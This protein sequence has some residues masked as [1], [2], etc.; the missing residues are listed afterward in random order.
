MKYKKYIFILCLAH[1]FG[2]CGESALE[3]ASEC[4]GSTPRCDGDQLITCEFV[5][6]A[7]QEQIQPE[8]CKSATLSVAVLQFQ[9]DPTLTTY[10]FDSFETLLTEALPNAT[11]GLVDISIDARYVLPF[12]VEDS[13]HDFANLPRQEDDP[14]NFPDYIHPDD[15]PRLWY[16]YKGVDQVLTDVEHA[17]ADIDLTAF[18]LIVVITDVS[19]GAIAWFL[20]GETL[21]FV[22]LN[23]FT[24]G[25]WGLGPDYT[26]RAAH[27]YS[28]VDEAIH[29][30]G[31]Y[32]GLGHSC[33]DA[34]PA[35]QFDDSCCDTCSSR[36]D[37][38]SSICR[39]RPSELEDEFY[40]SF[41]ACSLEHIQ[42]SFVPAFVTGA[43]VPVQ[44]V[45]C[46]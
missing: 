16:W 19:L 36:G 26:R 28:L 35:P 40:N 34:C 6:G 22:V 5:D 45:S 4:N 12:P 14:D 21:S 10:N 27:E 39:D 15:F 3:C 11:D 31:H 23:N 38:M 46:E 33:S 25:G 1:L 32:M 30:L 42:S 17:A 41:S 18:D 7:C 24:I 20:V 43:L 29:E 37:V 8:S 9:S 44:Q 13:V 2:S